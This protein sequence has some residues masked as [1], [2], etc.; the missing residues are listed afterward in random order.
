VSDTYRDVGY[1]SYEIGAG[2]R[3][4]ILVVD[5][6]VAFTDPKY[7]LGGLPMIHAA[8]DRTAELLPLA[9]ERGVPVAACYTAY[10]SLDD[11]PLWKVKAVRD[12]F[13]YGHPCTEI[14]AQ[15]HHPSNFTY[16]KNAP[17]MFFQTPLITFLVRQAVDTVIITGCTT[18]GC[19]RATI[20]DAFSYGFRVLVP[21]DCVG[22]ADE[23]QHRSNLADVAR[24][25]ADVTDAKA[26][27]AYFETLPVGS[28]RVAD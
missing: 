4:A 10:C 14:D 19:V 1:G 7:A 28:G 27:R 16:C 2:R 25:Y 6:Q 26:I 13:Y 22:D 12:E 9:R 3:P 24:R 23:T 11:M 5:L 18:S 20:I 15:I 8:R 17:S 21:Q